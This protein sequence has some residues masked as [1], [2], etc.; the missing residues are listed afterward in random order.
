M[1][2][3]STISYFDECLKHIVE[4]APVSEGYLEAFLYHFEDG[5]NFERVGHAQ[6]G[7]SN[8]SDTFIRAIEL[9]ELKIFLGEI[10]SRWIDIRQA[11]NFQEERIAFAF[12]I[13]LL[14]CPYR[15][16]VLFTHQQY[17]DSIEEYVKT[18]RWDEWEA[19]S[20]LDF[21][22]KFLIALINRENDVQD[23]FV[24]EFTKSLAGCLRPV[25][26]RINSEPWIDFH[27]IEDDEVEILHLD[28]GDKYHLV[29]HLKST[30]IFNR[31]EHPLPGK[32]LQLQLLKKF[33]EN[34]FILLEESYSFRKKQSTFLNGFLS[35]VTQGQ[36]RIATEV[37]LINRK[38]KILQENT[39]FEAEPIGRIYSPYEFFA[40]STGWH[41][42]FNNRMIK[43]RGNFKGLQY[44][45]NMLLHPQKKFNTHELEP[46]AKKSGESDLSY[47]V[48]NSVV[49]EIDS[50][51]NKYTNDS[52]EE[53]LAALERMTQEKMD[54]SDI[55]EN[56]I[57][58]Y[59]QLC[60]LS[61]SLKNVNSTQKY[62]NLNNYYKDELSKLLYELKV[63]YDDD[64]YVTRIIS[65]SK[66][67]RTVDKSFHEKSRDQLRDNLVK[68]I[69]NAIKGIQDEET[70]EYFKNCVKAGVKSYFTPD[71]NRPIAW[72]LS[73]D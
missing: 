11:P 66:A 44:I 39:S 21:S 53:L 5:K 15:V 62:I 7:S 2:E 48:N 58:Y 10:D 1:S 4:S 63:V 27:H 64:A 9:S 30:E 25:T 14:T 61:E 50:I 40:N 51:F 24:S 56:K 20:M 42:R 3:Y 12:R 49:L 32:L 18:Y 34:V 19:I 59:S 71:V 26:Y 33:I 52:E 6:N 45:H 65:K 67:I 60:H 68:N 46:F 41:I 22:Q 70:R 16:L 47:F 36:A 73:S 23:Q 35:E 55:L 13:P 43:T 54:E 37:E 28:L 29:L 17:R 8:L 57:F 31:N 69:Q 38:I 72:G